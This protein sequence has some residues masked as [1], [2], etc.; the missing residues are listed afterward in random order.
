MTPGQADAPVARRGRSATRS[1]PPPTVSVRPNRI[2]SW[3]TS[4][5]H[6]PDQKHE[7]EGG[8]HTSFLPPQPQP[9][10]PEQQRRRQ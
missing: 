1:M 4:S 8:G 7:D 2:T 6:W 10:R 3:T 5:P 9:R